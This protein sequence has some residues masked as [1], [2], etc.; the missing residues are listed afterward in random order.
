MDAKLA[1]TYYSPDGSWKGL[2]AIKKLAEV[3][4][5]PEDAAK[6]VAVEAGA[7]ADLF[8]CATQHVPRPKF[9]VPT[10]NKMHQ[11]DFLV[12]PYDKLPR[13]RKGVSSTR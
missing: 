13:G 1:K 9:D 4:K 6:K 7:L 11:A 12:L 2:V 10:P 8:P 5:V 3:A